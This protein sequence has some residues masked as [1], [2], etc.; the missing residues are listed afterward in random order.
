MTELLIDECLNAELA[1]MARERRHYE[2]FNVVWI[3]NPAGET[4][5]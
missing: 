5:S 3:G 4:G 1:L 2:A